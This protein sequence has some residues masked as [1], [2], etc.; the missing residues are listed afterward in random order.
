MRQVHWKDFTEAD[1]SWEDPANLPEIAAK[2][3]AP[4][5]RAPLSRS[6]SLLCASRRREERVPAAFT[7]SAAQVIAWHLK[8]P[9]SKDRQGVLQVCVPQPVYLGRLSI[10]RDALRP[11]LRL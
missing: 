10:A 6:G 8:Q 4:P 3:V 7:V 11:L 9:G 5:S 1:D 2:K